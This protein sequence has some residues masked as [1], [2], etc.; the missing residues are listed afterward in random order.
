MNTL[1]TGKESDPPSREYC[2]ALIDKYDM[3]PNI[4]DHSLKVRDVSMII[5]EAVDRADGS[6]DLPLVEAGALLHDITKT[7]SIDNKEKENHAQ[8]GE[9]LLV[10]LGFPK[11]GKVVGEHII[12]DERGG[13]LTAAEIVS[14]ADKRVLHDEV[15]DLEARYEY[16]MERYGRFPAALEFYDLMRHRMH[17]IERLIERLTKIPLEELNLS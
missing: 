16:L 11:T 5:A 7:R 3:L 17:Q 15:V 4:R 6:I 9:E 12:P 2:M 10:E 14:Y 8:T 1:E 13:I